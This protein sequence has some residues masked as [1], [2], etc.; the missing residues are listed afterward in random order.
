MALA[1]MNRASTARDIAMTPNTGADSNLWLLK[2]F[3]KHIGVLFVHYAIYDKHGRKCGQQHEFYSGFFIILDGQWYFVTA[4]HVFWREPEDKEIGLLQALKAGRIRFIE[5]SLAEYF[6]RNAKSRIST[7][8]SAE[9]VVETVVYVNNSALGLDFALIPLRQ[10]YVDSIKANGIEPLTQWCEDEATMYA[11]IGFPADEQ[12]KYPARPNDI[13]AGVLHTAMIMMEKCERPDH[14][15]KSKLP[16]FAAKLPDDEP[17][18][19]VGF[20]GSPIFAVHQVSE[21]TGYCLLGIDYA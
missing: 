20:S 10:W 21:R 13:R 19:A 18:S 4:G 11:V 2:H 8:L 3:S 12:Q 5:M 15:T 14:H 6:G 17:Y 9:E 1:P 16:V 7:V